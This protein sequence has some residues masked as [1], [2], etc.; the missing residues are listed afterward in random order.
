MI[1]KIVPIRVLATSIMNKKNDKQVHTIQVLPL[2]ASKKFK[3]VEVCHSDATHAC[4]VTSSMWMPAFGP[5]DLVRMHG[6]INGHKVWIMVDDGATHNF[7]NYKLVKKLKLPQ[8]PSEH[9]YMVSLVNG[10]DKTVWDTVVKDVALSIQDFD[11]HLDF[12]VMHIT[13]ADIILGR[14]WL[15]SLGPTL[16]RSYIDNTLEFEANGKHICLHGEHD[17]PASPMICAIEVDHLVHTNAIENIFLCYLCPQVSF[18]NVNSFDKDCDVQMSNVPSIHAM[19]VTKNESQ[20]SYQLSQK[21]DNS[22]QQLLHEFQD[23]FPTD[24]LAGLPP[25][26]QVQHSIDVLKDSKLCLQAPL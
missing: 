18:D 24:L 13:R 19:Q 22:L 5:Y 25:A 23:V 9:K 7:L 21:F 16:S 12:Q 2:D 20:I 8:T 3:E 10:H 17:V 14:E 4:C 1:R 15:F 6:F 11:M 26:R